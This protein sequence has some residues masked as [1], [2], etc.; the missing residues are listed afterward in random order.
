M[1]APNYQ[2]QQF[3]ETFPP[4]VRDYL[5]NI[6]QTDGMLDTEVSGSFLLKGLHIGAEDI[7]RFSKRL[8]HRGIDFGFEFFVLTFEVNHR[9]LH[10]FN[11]LSCLY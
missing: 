2:F 8:D 9:D 5:Q 11:L 4:S 1:I 10:G 6:P 3:L 7:A